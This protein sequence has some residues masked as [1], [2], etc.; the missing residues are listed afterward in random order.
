LHDV[1]IHSTDH[2]NQQARWEGSFFSMMF[3]YLAGAI[4]WLVYGLLLHAGAV[5]W[6]HG[7]T[8]AVVLVAL[9]LKVTHPGRG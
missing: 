9:V 4:L 3:L 7:I 6:A 8:F 2:K 1:G 5:I